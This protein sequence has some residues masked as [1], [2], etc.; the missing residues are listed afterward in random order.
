MLATKLS[1]DF[2]DRVYNDSLVR[3]S[4]HI[5]Q[6]FSEYVDGIEIMDE[7]RKMLIVEDSEYYSLFDEDDRQE[8]LFCIFKLLCLGG[9]LC[10]PEQTIE[11][12]LEAT[13]ALYKD[14]VSVTKDAKTNKIRV[15]SE[16]YKIQAFD[17]EKNLIYPCPH[18]HPQNVAYAIVDPIRRHV[19]VLYHR[20]GIGQLPKVN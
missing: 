8:L 6:C 20:F 5:C 3:K 18:D 4:G 7:V 19:T 16:V 17:S 2:F 13:K 1:L 11:P 9:E 12:I 10:Q 14:C 15:C